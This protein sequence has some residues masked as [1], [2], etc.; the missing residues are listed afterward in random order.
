MAGLL[1]PQQQ[2]LMMMGLYAGSGG[3]VPHT[4]GLPAS[5]G[6]GPGDFPAS[7]AS[8]P[9]GLGGGFGGGGM[10]LQHPH[11]PHQHLQHHQVLQQQ[12]QQQEAEHQALMA[13]LAAA[14]G[15]GRPQVMLFR[16]LWQIVF[17]RTFAAVR[18]TAGRALD[19]A[20]CVF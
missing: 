9:N 8:L 6:F 17:A 19:G 10:P 18:P 4:A 12:R 14:G 15:G 7:A 5:G 11:Q 3:G 16:G 20:P 13:V 2:Q 1:S